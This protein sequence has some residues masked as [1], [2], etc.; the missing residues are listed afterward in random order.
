MERKER[1]DRFTEVEDRFADYEV[2]DPNGEKIGK[3]DDLFVDENDQPEYLEVKMG[4]LGMRATLIPWKVVS[5]VD[6]EAKRIEAS[7]E[8]DKAEDGPAFNDA[9]QNITPSFEN[10][11]Y[12]YYGLQRE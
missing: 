11:V 7:V 3:A 10:E 6:D 4:F 2:Y 8:K 1:N 9:H 12:S 5:N